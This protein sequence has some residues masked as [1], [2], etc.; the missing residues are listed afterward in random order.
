MHCYHVCRIVCPLGMLYSLSTLLPKVFFIENS[1]NSSILQQNLHVYVTN[2]LNFQNVY[3]V[4]FKFLLNMKKCFHIE[5]S[6]FLPVTLCVPTF[7]NVL[8]K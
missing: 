6:I 8:V 4:K 5:V 1:S 2:N 3:W 7:T